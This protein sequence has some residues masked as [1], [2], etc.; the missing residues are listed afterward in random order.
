[1]KLQSITFE[2]DQSDVQLSIQPGSNSSK[3]Y[4]GARGDI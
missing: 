4:I 1:M 2:A 3:L